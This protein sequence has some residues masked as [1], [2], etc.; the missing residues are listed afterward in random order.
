MARSDANAQVR[1]QLRPTAGVQSYLRVVARLQKRGMSWLLV[2]GDI[3]IEVKPRW[4]RRGDVLDR[5][6]LW[7]LRSSNDVYDAIPSR[8]QPTRLLKAQ[9]DG[10]F[11]SGLQA[12]AGKSRAAVPSARKLGRT[13]G[14]A[15][16]S[17]L[18]QL[19]ANRIDLGRVPAR[20]P[21]FVSGGL[22][23]LGHRR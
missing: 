6:L 9:P 23:G 7:H 17:G 18:P 14:G 15:R 11:P 13:K 20:G 12:A 22:P 8:H 2:T 5:Q 3:A 1:H 21:T 19:R 4:R 10:R 16:S